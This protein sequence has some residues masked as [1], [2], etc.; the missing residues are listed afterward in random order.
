PARLAQLRAQMDQRRLDVIMR[1]LA[2]LVRRNLRGSDAVALEDEELLVM[3]DAPL[4]MAESVT[5]RLLAA[6][7]AHHFLGGAADRSVRLRGGSLVKGSCHVQRMT[8]PYA[9][10]AEVLRA[11][12]RLPVKSTRVWR[13][14]GALD[15]TLERPGEEATPG[16]SKMRLLEE[17]ADF[18][19]LAAQQ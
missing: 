9:L 18:L 5:T 3:L 7:R 8:E 1:E 15:P 6:V 17:L 19:R 16:G 14:L 11:V 10:W 4:G 12:R 2:L 13:E